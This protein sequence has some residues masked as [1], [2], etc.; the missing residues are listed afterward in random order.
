V[1]LIT[2]DTELGRHLA[3]LYLLLQ[4]SEMMSDEEKLA[5]QEPLKRFTHLIKHDP[6]DE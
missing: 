6:Y 4:Q 5:A 1:K 2:F 3:G